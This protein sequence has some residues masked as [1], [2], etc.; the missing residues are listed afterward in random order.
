MD[1]KTPAGKSIAFVREPK[2]GY[3]KIQ[4]SEGGELPQEL[5]GFFTTPVM[6]EKAV[7]AYIDSKT[8]K[9]K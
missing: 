8:T 6:A 5:Q 4:F 3:I 7:R 2:N 9:S 1:F